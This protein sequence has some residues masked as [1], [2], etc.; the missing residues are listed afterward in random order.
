MRLRVRCLAAALVAV[1]GGCGQGTLDTKAVRVQAESVASVATQGHILA[2]EAR[3]GRVLESFL[4][5][6][7]ADLA[8]DA[9]KSHEELKPELAMPRTKPA[10][11]KLETLSEG[12]SVQL[13]VIETQ[14]RDKGALA[15]SGAAL[16]RIAK[17]ASTIEEEL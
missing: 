13:R 15:K 6:H 12:A 14:P 10:V 5:V 1:G 9:A 16:D 8:D 4:Q 7:A 3:R 17:A 2:R 11:E